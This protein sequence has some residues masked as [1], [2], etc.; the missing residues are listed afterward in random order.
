M[1]PGTEHACGVSGRADE[2]SPNTTVLERF[3]GIV[4]RATCCRVQPQEERMM[5]IMFGNAHTAHARINQ[6]W[7]VQEAVCVKLIAR[8]QPNGARHNPTEEAMKNP[9]AYPHDS[10]SVAQ[11]ATD[12]CSLPISHREL[13]LFNETSA[14]Q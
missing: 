6:Y 10:A 3:A 7:N 12:A 5:R 8:E 2:E 1:K 11:H 13:H 9:I 4:R 14:G